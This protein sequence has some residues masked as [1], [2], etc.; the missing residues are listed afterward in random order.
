MAII[1][2]DSKND[3]VYV[4]M[5]DTDTIREIDDNNMLCSK[6]ASSLMAGYVIIDD[7]TELCVIKGFR[8]A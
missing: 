3:K 7:H 6:A 4:L 2:L 8:K 1:T 5:D